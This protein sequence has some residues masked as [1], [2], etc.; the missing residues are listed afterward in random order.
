MQKKTFDLIKELEK[1]YNV[2][3]DGKDFMVDDLTF[4]EWKDNKLL[5]TYLEKTEF[6]DYKGD[7]EYDTADEVISCEIDEVMW[8]INSERDY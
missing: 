4:T 7:P 8:W 5:V 3:V 1:N 2:R 6:K